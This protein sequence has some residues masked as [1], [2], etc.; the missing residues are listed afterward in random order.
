MVV[1]VD[2]HREV[3]EEGNPEMTRL[4]VAVWPPEEVVEELRALPRKDQR[5]VRFVGPEQWHV[6]LRFLGDADPLHVASA[7]DGCRL[8]SATA[9]LGPGVDV[10]G[11]RSL[12]IPV[13]GLDVLAAEVRDLTAHI[14]E[15]ARQRF[16]GHLTLARLKHYA[17][18]PRALG[19]SLSAEFEAEEVALV[20]SRLHPDGA[21]YETIET[22]RLG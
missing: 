15:P 7:L 1:E 21:R 5:G 17:S 4:F 3:A 11:E 20:E 2:C 8:T 18:M 6:T 12:V 14:G 19:M 9:R 10:L 22:W 16:V 13:G